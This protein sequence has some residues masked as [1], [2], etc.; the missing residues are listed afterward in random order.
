MARRTHSVPGES[1]FERCFVRCAD[2]RWDRQM[3]LM[4]R[5][6]FS[7][8]ND[9]S[10]IARWLRFVYLTLPPD[11]EEIDEQEIAIQRVRRIGRAAKVRRPA[12]RTRVAS[13]LLEMVATEVLQN[14]DLEV[15]HYQEADSFRDSRSA[16]RSRRQAYRT[17]GARRTS[18]VPSQLIS[19]PST[20]RRILDRAET[21]WS[22]RRIPGEHLGLG[23]RANSA[24]APHLRW[25][26]ANLV[27][28][29]NPDVPGSEVSQEEP[30]ALGGS[31]RA[32]PSRAARRP[33]ERALAQTAR[34][35]GSD[36]FAVLQDLTAASGGARR[37]TLETL[38][39]RSQTMEKTSQ[40]RVIRRQLSRMTGPLVTAARAELA[41]GAKGQNR[42]VR[43]AASRSLP[44]DS[45]ARSF[46]PVIASLPSFV[47]L[48]ND[49]PEFAA[50]EKIA[51]GQVAPR[52]TQ[53]LK[54]LGAYRQPTQARSHRLARSQMTVG[55]AGPKVGTAAEAAET[56]FDA[57]VHRVAHTEWTARLGLGSEQNANNPGVRRGTDALRSVS[58]LAINTPVE[59]V[60]R[61]AEIARDYG[62]GRMRPASPW[63]S[64][65][66]GAVPSR[67]DSTQ[68]IRP[69][70]TISSAQRGDIGEMERAT[71]LVRRLA[72][73]V[74]SASVKPLHRA[75]RRAT[76]FR[77][78]RLALSA[79][80]TSY[81]ESGLL[82]KSD[83]S[84]SVEL[85]ESSGWRRA[86]SR[87]QHDVTVRR[88]RGTVPQQIQPALVSSS[89]IQRLINP[90]FDPLITVERA[91]RTGVG[92]GLAQ[93]SVERAESGRSIS[94]RRISLTGPEQTFVD[95]QET[96]PEADSEMRSEDRPTLTAARRLESDVSARV[97]RDSEGRQRDES[98]TQGLD[99]RRVSSS[100][101]RRTISSDQSSTSSERRRTAS[102][103]RFASSSDRF[104]SSSDRLSTSPDRLG[105]S[106]TRGDVFV[107]SARR[108]EATY[109]G[110]RGPYTVEPDGTIVSVGG[111]VSRSTSRYTEPTRRAW[112]RGQS[113]R[114]LHRQEAGRIFTNPMSHLE[115]SESAWEPKSIK[116]A[117]DP[118][119][120]RLARNQ[121]KAQQRVARPEGYSLDA[122]FTGPTLRAAQ[123]GRAMGRLSAHSGLWRLDV[124][125]QHIQSEDLMSLSTPLT[126]E[127]GVSRP[128]NRAAM[129][130]VS[131]PAYD[132]RGVLRANKSPAGHVR[133]MREVKAR[134]LSSQQLAERLLGQGVSAESARIFDR[135]GESPTGRIAQRSAA[136]NV[137]TNQFRGGLRSVP[138]AYLQTNPV[139]SIAADVVSPWAGAA[140]N[141]RHQGIGRAARVD[142]RVSRR[143]H[144]TSPMETLLQGD[145]LD[146]EDS[147]SPD[148]GDVSEFSA[149]RTF[150]APPLSHATNRLDVAR[151]V[152]SRG[153]GRIVS[154]PM[155]T[156]SVRTESVSGRPLSRLY[157]ADRGIDIGI[158][159]KG[160]VLRRAR[161]ET[162]YFE[163]LAGGDASETAEPNASERVYRRSAG[164]SRWGRKQARQTD[165]LVR[166][167]SAAY[168]TSRLALSA[169][170][171]AAG[172]RPTRRGV[173]TE[174]ERPLVNTRLDRRTVSR[175]RGLMPAPTAHVV[176]SADMSWLDPEPQ[177]GA[178]GSTVVEAIG[179]GRRMSA[180]AGRVSSYES[181][182]APSFEV[183]GSRR[184]AR[185]EFSRRGASTSRGT[186]RR[187]HSGGPEFEY[188]ESSFNHSYDSEPEHGYPG[189]LGQ[190]GGSHLQWAQ[191][192]G[193]HGETRHNR[194]SYIG[195][196]RLAFGTG[197]NHS[198]DGNI[199]SWAERAAHGDLSTMRLARR[200]T[201]MRVESIQRL[202]QS[203]SVEQMLGVLAQ[204]RRSLQEVSEFL[205]GK[206]AKVL[207]DLVSLDSQAMNRASEKRAE[208]KLR[209]DSQGRERGRKTLQQTTLAGPRRKA[210]SG[211]GGGGRASHL[212]N[213]LLKLIHL[214]EV[215]RRVD[216]AQK[217]VRMSQQSPGGGVTP[218]T[219][220]GGADKDSVPNTKELYREALAYVQDQLER[221]RLRNMGN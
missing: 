93:S 103:D 96:Q 47:N 202:V 100:S 187:R 171:P 189:H 192:I 69:S 32:S 158:V 53:Q 54:A 40:E 82:G 14:Q 209:A 109:L 97:V 20:R 25:S 66:R 219:D 156:G 99:S 105:R 106:D 194:S 140:T 7:P 21:Q 29:Q 148:I 75:G 172:G 151:G 154:S 39:S 111:E 27:F 101:G 127:G 123:R 50:I 142:S 58:T 119:I 114:R 117:R 67:L 126:D 143:T 155:R 26:Q 110:L 176:A 205:P 88:H 24:P 183:P 195:T 34:T 79:I 191:T 84:A 10:G 76:S 102:S 217:E 125:M 104:A 190:P 147:A 178:L 35:V 206:A 153:A 181:R 203:Q 55:R 17:S 112:S 98:V 13:K 165:K 116:V 129:R 130:S 175:R 197:D 85:Q 162:P 41:S 108:A 121:T 6:G 45:P 186:T 64:A 87:S 137:V 220:A 146:R 78:S 179:G 65:L 59:H 199:P 38:V 118:F 159:R 5:F 73:S 149:P 57:Q 94:K 134:D 113:P 215:E 201:K 91:A 139:D 212:A 174:I 132:S 89:R 80:P 19:A 74:D 122:R 120:K 2:P 70:R 12:R 44:F 95:G 164:V 196:L 157:A 177:K 4:D 30:F 185:T 200:Q 18:R 52:S 62:Y 214:A 43:R 63:N 218:G 145:R 42:S 71:N 11:D 168:A 49:S 81:V 68:F 3:S 107:R 160:R 90:T 60:V 72:R 204:H 61:R 86:S 16:S 169:A 31:R 1:I 28:A 216:D 163:V 150:E 213:Q 133:S 128:L 77:P 124:P 188:A 211:Q 115:A 193:R 48:T 198:M 180:G 131:V 221:D 207:D 51:G 136:G 152:D 210:Q 184:A 144:V 166:A 135:I 9:L 167:G 37:R 23:H 22:A 33:V 56:A 182:T 208:A 170:L 92:D 46:R 8:K 141:D 36:A 173:S 138:T 161:T 15:P 83:E